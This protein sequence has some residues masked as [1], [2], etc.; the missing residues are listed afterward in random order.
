MSK[1]TPVFDADKPY[2]TITS[3]DAANGHWEQFGA[4]FDGEGNFLKYV[5][6]YDATVHAE[7]KP[8]RKRRQRVSVRKLKQDTVVPDEID[9]NEEMKQDIAAQISE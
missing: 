1:A 7:K 5:E 2:A 4:L 8:V 3:F 6:G 9:A